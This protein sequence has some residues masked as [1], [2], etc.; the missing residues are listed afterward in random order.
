[1]SL[2]TLLL[3]LAVTCASCTSSLS[4][5]ASSTTST[6]AVPT[7][8]TG[9]VVKTGTA[10]GIPSA[11][12]T[13]ADSLSN[14]STTTADATG[15][16]T[17]A[18]LAAGNYELQ[19]AAPGYEV[20]V[21]SL[22]FPVSGYTVQLAPVGSAPVSTLMVSIAGPATLAVGQSSQL[23]ASV[24]Y[25][26]GTQ[27]DVTNVATWKSTV[28]SVATI[29]HTGLLTAYSAGATVITAAFQDVS[30]SLPIATTS[31]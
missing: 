14:I 13:L 5:T 22:I 8:L 3:C 2:R 29:S 4:P 10:I 18:N 16:F 15:A 9:R 20:S 25:T 17:F 30:G 12:L 27:K 28:S 7:S 23:T 6:P 1:M 24:V 31:P 19:A 21:S 26:D 11:A